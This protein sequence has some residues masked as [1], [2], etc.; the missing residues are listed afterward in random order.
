MFSVSQGEQGQD[1][2]RQG[3]SSQGTCGPDSFPT[4]SPAPGSP[5]RRVAE[6]SPAVPR[7]LRNWIRDSSLEKWLLGQSEA[8]DGIPGG[9]KHVDRGEQPV[10]PAPQAE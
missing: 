4:T 5:W 6:G 7:I 10:G 2:E 1:A 3:R 9:E 8:K